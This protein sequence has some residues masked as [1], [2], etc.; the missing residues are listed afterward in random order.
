MKIIKN[1]KLLALT[2]FICLLPIAMYLA[3]YNSLPEQM[4]QQW[5]T[6]GT[7][8]W[9]MPRQWAILVLP[10][11]LTLV[12]LIVVFAV[13]LDPKRENTAPVMHNLIYWL[14]PVASIFANL[15][16]L[17]ANLGVNFDVGAATLVFVGLLFVI[18]GN[19]LP[20]T[21][22]NYTVGFRVPWTLNDA[23]NWSQTHRLAGRLLVLGGIL[24]I[25][26][27][28]LPLPPAALVALLI[29]V[30][31]LIVVVPTLYSISIYRKSK[32]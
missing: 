20:K 29:S 16:I 28:V 5:G 25:L 3:V 21:R 11:F 19:Y 8:N 6:D 10:L 13:N 26:G 27:A 23:D 4:I 14:M 30:L 17:F 18:I 24:F 12:H 31:V 9:T 15:T 32:G 7:G 22:Q 2:T 1:K